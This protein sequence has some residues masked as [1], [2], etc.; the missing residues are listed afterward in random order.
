MQNTFGDCGQAPINSVIVDLKS[1]AKGCRSLVSR[2]TH[3]RAT[4]LRHFHHS[5]VRTNSIQGSPSES[6]TP[7]H[8]GKL[9]SSPDPLLSEA[10]CKDSSYCWYE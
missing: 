9:I 5:L 2:K 4:F 3:S 6:Q 7:R 1:I 10:R 8:R